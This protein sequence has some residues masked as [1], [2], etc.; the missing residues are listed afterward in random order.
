MSSRLASS[1]SP[2]S[3]CKKHRITYRERVYADPNRPGVAVTHRC[4]SRAAKLGAKRRR[5]S[6]LERYLAQP[7]YLRHLFPRPDLERRIREQDETP[8][9]RLTK[10]S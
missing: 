1:S 5:D 10:A 9:R 4:R 8:K 7:G 3:I 2:R 6:A